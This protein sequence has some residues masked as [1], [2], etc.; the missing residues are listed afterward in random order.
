MIRLATSFLFFCELATLAQS[1]TQWGGNAQHTGTVG[2]AGQLPRGVLA[3]IRYDP[4]AKAAQAE[5]GGN[6]LAHYQAPLTGGRDV[7]M[8]F[9]SGHYLSCS[10]PGSGRPR[11]CGVEAWDRQVWE[12]WALRWRGDRLM[13][14]W[15]YQSDWKPVPNDGGGLSGWEPVFHGALNGNDVWV[16]AA[17]GDV[18]QLRRRDG[19]LRKRHQPFGEEINGERYV[20][21]PLTIDGRGHVYYNVIELNPAGRWTQDI[22]G[23]WLVK[24]ARN[25]TITKTA[26]S[27][28]IRDAPVECKGSFGSALPW[29]PSPT[30]EPPSAPCLSQRPGINIAPAV[31]PDGT[32]YTVSR[33]HA[34]V[35]GRYAYLIALHPDLSW[36]W[37]ASLRGRLRDGCGVRLP[38]G[39]PG[40]CRAGTPATG[41]DP[42][43]NELPAGGVADLS[44]SSP[45]V[46]PDGSILY[47]AVTGYNHQRGHLMQFSA[48]GEFRNAYDFGWDTTPAIWE[49][50]GTYSVVIK[51]NNYPIGSYCF[52][53]QWCPPQPN[54]PYYI[55]QLDAS[56]KVEWKFENRNTENCARQPDGSL[57]CTP[58]RPGG[59][60]WCIN[61]PA[62][63]ALGNVYANSEDGNLYMIGQ[64]GREMGRLFLNLALGAAYTPL[65][66]GFDGK[67]YTENDGILFAAGK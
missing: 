25:G 10:P 62:V 35:G 2:V 55:T 45:V 41:V 12:M 66:I 24:I 15:A 27:A 9:K 48:E 34:P 53:S 8:A 50:D 59:F 58:A 11:P 44:T 5:T 21:S 23:A 20:V 32:V 18:V 37:Q 19:A 38:I 60:E 36:K 42:T 52:D 54:G 26:Y 7:F 49:H 40:G 63:D 29:P 51:E 16:P 3:E 33:G 56:L 46:A 39:L 47:G 17:G 57:R 65:S 30:A 4:F 13:E 1:W 31:A 61:A 22:R 64:G 6:L 67:I 28:L 43:T 14:R